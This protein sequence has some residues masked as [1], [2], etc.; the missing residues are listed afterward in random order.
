[1]RIATT[2]SA[3]FVGGAV[4][5]RLLARGDTVVALVRDPASFPGPANDGPER[6]DRLELVAS[7]LSDTATIA[8][9]VRGCDALIHGAG[10]YRIGI[11]KVER[12][13]M[14]DANVG[15]TGRVLDAALAAGIPRIIYISTVNTFGN[16]RG[17]IVDES[18]RRD[19]RDPY[20][21]CYDET[22]WLAHLE[23]ERRIDA[24]APVVIALPSQVYGP[25]DH[26]PVGGQFAAAYAG[27]LPFIGL[28]G[29]GLGLVHVDDL[30]DGILA[31]LDRGRAGRSY[32][33]SG[34]TVRMRDALAIAA[35]AGGHRLPRL[36]VPD[37][38]LRIGAA[39]LPNAGRWFGLS[40]NLRE[41]VSASVGVTY[42]ASS[43]RAAAELGFTARP[44]DEGFA[45]T[46]SRAGEGP[47]R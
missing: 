16:T 20:L 25:G 37:L 39:V 35:R 13:A 47:A 29:L 14:V 26:S 44:L 34:P 9:A 18:F 43:A 19:P 12:P 1:M 24:G 32:V 30:A 4:M 27:T 21:S 3:G 7:D 23:A 10:S 40:P 5:R 41:I 42:W 46:Y 36:V 2:G 8:D 22:K 6:H 11:P 15:V 31:A 28:G 33:L 17:R 38:P 45:D